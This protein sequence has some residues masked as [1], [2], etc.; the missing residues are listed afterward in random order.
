MS[1]KKIYSLLAMYAAM[2]GVSSANSLYET[3]NYKPKSTPEKHEKPIVIDE[4]KL[5]EARGLKKFYYG[6]EYI[7]A[8]NQKSAD[9]KAIK[10]GLITK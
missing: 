6:S 5:N 4:D 1:Q 8:L 3:P 2:G 10:K 9:K 7:W